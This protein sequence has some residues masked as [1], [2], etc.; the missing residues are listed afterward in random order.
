MAP[1]V[2][3]VH[4]VHKGFRLYH[5][6]NVSLKS[7][8]LDR[9]KRARYDIYEALKGVSFE[10][11][12]GKTFGLV[13]SNGSG[14]STMLKCIAGILVP[15]AGTISVRGRVASL[16][17]LGSGFHPELSGRDNVFL[18]AS[19][20]GLSR[21]ETAARFDEIVDFSGIEDFIDSPVKNYSSGMYVRLG[22]S[23]AIHVQPELFLVDEV[24]AVGDEQ[25][26]RKCAAKFTDLQEQGTTIVLVTHSMGQVLDLCDEAIWLDKGVPR[27]VSDAE[28]VVGAYLDE[29]DRI[30]SGHDVI[31]DARVTLVDRDDRPVKEIPTLTPLRARVDIELATAVEEVNVRVE[32]LD[33]RG[34]PIVDGRAEVSANGTTS[35]QT[36][37]NL[38]ALPL[39]VGEYLVRAWI[40]AKGQK[41]ATSA[42]AR[43][44][45]PGDEK[46][47][48]ILSTPVTFEPT[49]VGEPQ[50]S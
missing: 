32:M 36:T 16:L 46:H 3:E 24:L 40:E 15:D 10:V 18:N 31:K 17:E 19:I 29:Q 42:S 21:K 2:V 41:D 5:E 1:P 30:G 38:P 20:L 37:A 25:F 11:S 6:R 7:V 13:G 27:L 12:E 47:I 49:S 44:V 9:G 50:D 39:R 35:L 22:F 23:V 43:F 34:I 48:V 28:T 14:K 33:N 4:D 26:Q 45:V 8:V